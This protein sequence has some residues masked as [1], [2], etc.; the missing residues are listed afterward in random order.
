MP[1][2]PKAK[3]KKWIASSSNKSGYKA[4]HLSVNS[5]FYNSTAWRELRKWFIKSNPTCKW[6]SEE[7]RANINNLIVDHI[8]EI[9]DGGEKLDPENLQTLCLSHHNQKTNWAKAKRKKKGD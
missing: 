7:G 6:C 2:L 4:K 9:V 1:T 3:K 8:V 5:E